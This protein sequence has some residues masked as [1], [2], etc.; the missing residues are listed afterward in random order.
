MFSLI[1]VLWDLL[2]RL[3]ALR[4]E[5]Y[6]SQQLKRMDATVRSKYFQILVADVEIF[7]IYKNP[8]KALCDWFYALQH[9]QTS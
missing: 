8:S 2:D 6:L 5:S 4:A 9:L 3:I 1:D 7:K